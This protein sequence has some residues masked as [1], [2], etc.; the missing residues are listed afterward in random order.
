MF[1]MYWKNI[2]NGFKLNSVLILRVAT[3][4]IVL[5]GVFSLFY[6]QMRKIE[7][8]QSVLERFEGKHA[9]I[10]TSEGVMVFQLFENEAPTAIER[11]EK[12]SNEELFYDGLEF[13]R[14]SQNF[15]I[16]GGIQNFA[17]KYL[18]YEVDNDFI[19]SKVAKLGTDTFPVESNYASLG[20]TEEEILELENKG[21]K[22]TDGIQSRKFEYGSLSFA[23]NGFEGNST[24]LFIV[25]SKEGNSESVDF[26]NGR[27]TNM[28]IIVE[29]KDVLDRISE[30]E[31]DIDYPVE[32]SSDRS[33]PKKQIVIFEV[34][35]N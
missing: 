3:G 20:L 29:G 33:Y 6:Y 27:F 23:N 7:S 8:C 14:I 31:I 9:C 32:F 18:G 17:A 10:S 26:L 1:N 19:N 35:V 12:L 13:Y 2:F 21:Y 24:E 25:F 16:Q 34:R 4:L 5:A 15:V 11:L 22:S 28:G 30:T